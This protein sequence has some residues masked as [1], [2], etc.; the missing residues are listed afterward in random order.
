MSTRSPARSGNQRD[1]ETG[2]CWRRSNESAL[3]PAVDRAVVSSGVVDLVTRRGGA[4]RYLTTE[5]F[6][7]ARMSAFT[8]LPRIHDGSERPPSAGPYDVGLRSCLTD[9]RVGSR[10]CRKIEDRWLY[11]RA[12]SRS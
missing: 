10:P 5:S 7:A 11:R 2:P 8:K 1:R 4:G 3:T 12:A 9:V 6:R